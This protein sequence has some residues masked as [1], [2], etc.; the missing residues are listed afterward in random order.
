MFSFR[1]KKQ[2]SKD[3]AD[4]TFKL[5]KLILT[6]PVTNAVSE[7]FNVAQ[8]QNLPAII[9]DSRT[10]KFSFNSCHLQ[11][12]SSDKLKLVEVANQFWFKNEHRFYI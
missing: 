10:S 1:L 4:T 9:Y 11:K 8:I 6:V 2:T 12:E 3:V 5:V 7:R